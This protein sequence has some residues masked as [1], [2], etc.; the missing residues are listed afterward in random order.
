ML[1]AELLVRSY[2]TLR[3]DCNSGSSNLWG[4]LLKDTKWRR[5]V[6]ILYPARRSHRL[7]LIIANYK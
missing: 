7:F 5:K 6:G 3:E 1:D 4:V 2:L